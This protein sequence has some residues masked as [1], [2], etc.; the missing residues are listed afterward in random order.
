LLKPIRSTRRD[1]R[2]G[3]R[4]VDW[5]RDCLRWRVRA[6]IDGRQRY[7][8]VFVSITDAATAYANAV[9]LA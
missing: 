8:G 5:R 9:R 3:L 1:C 6:T 7:I 4:G 2:S